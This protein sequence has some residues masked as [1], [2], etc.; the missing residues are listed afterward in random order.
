MD[1]NEAIVKFREY[2]P[3]TSTTMWG[4]AFETICAKALESAPSASNNSAMVPCPYHSSFGTQCP[5]EVS[6]SCTVASC[7]IERA[8]PRHCF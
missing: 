6:W 3:D 2:W 5:L 1:V 8:Q 7:L 4:E